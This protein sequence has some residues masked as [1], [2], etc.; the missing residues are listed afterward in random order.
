MSVSPLPILRKAHE[1]MGKAFIFH[2]TTPGD[3]AFILSLRTDSQKAKY[4]LSLTSK[5]DIP[6]G[7]LRNHD[8]NESEVTS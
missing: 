1:G 3:A 2:D 4:L 6:I 5:F 8:E 7:W